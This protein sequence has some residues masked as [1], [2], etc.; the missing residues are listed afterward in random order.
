M[1][2]TMADVQKLINGMAMLAQAM[3]A[4]AQAQ[5]MNAQVAAASVPVS[6]GVIGGVGK[7]NRYIHP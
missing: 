4:N 6:G 5:A 3:T 1:A 2:A 7:S